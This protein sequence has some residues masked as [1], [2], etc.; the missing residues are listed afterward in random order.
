MI[1]LHRKTVTI[2]CSLCGVQTERSGR[3][4]TSF[5][6]ATKP[7]FLNMAVWSQHL[8]VWK[9]FDTKYLAGLG[10]D[11]WYAGDPA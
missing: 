2:Y 10:E 8:G 9:S 5:T 4:C 1:K 6:A 7:R 3:K 11:Q